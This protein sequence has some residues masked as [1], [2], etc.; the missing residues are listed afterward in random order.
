MFSDILEEYGSFDEGRV[1]K[2]LKC[3]A[4]MFS[5]NITKAMNRDTLSLSEHPPQ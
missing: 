5:Y 4:Q 3:C 1:R 2:G